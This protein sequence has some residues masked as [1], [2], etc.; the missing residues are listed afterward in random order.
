[1]SEIR[2]LQESEYYE[3]MRIVAEA[4][5]SM[6]VTTPDDI[7]KW[8]QRFKIGRRDPDWT[9]YG[10]FRDGKMVGVYRN[11][12]FIMNVRGNLLSAGGLGMVAVDLT[13][14]KE[15]VAKEIVDAFL[16]HYDKRGDA[17]TCLWPFRVDFY[18]RMGFGLGYRRYQ[19]RVHPAS[20]PPRREKDH[21]RYLTEV[22]IPAIVE[23]YNRCFEKQS[24]MI[25]HNEGRY[26]NRFQYAEKQRYIGCEVDGR[27][28]GYLIYSFKNTDRPNSFMD[29]DLVVTEFF[30][31]TPQ[32]LSELLAFLHSQLDQV[33][34][35]LLETSEDEFYFLMS[36]P[37]IASG[38]KMAPTYH[39]SHMAGVGIMYRVMDLGRLFDKLE[40]PCFG[41]DRLS[42]RINLTD[43]FLPQ[44]NGPRVV[45]FKGGRGK[46]ADTDQA[47]VEIALD[48]AE[49]SSLI[50]AAVGFEK[51]YTYGLAQ[52]SDQ[53]FINRLDR[54]FAYHQKPVCITG[55]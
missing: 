17:M 9:P 50:M 42:V 55:F 38:T 22:D 44:Y 16:S 24:G 3:S 27:L 23:C 45:Q 53:T 49:F 36:D 33:S 8:E 4:Y 6:G 32:A 7:R 34:R 48:V 10:V 30:Y 14:K 52:V 54:L 51:L 41:D 1:V 37:T 29:T 20:L 15:H 47:D 39:E 19:Y 18:H 11:F 5:P 21:I 12:D 28:D 2:V 43:P 25:R 26:L 46:V 13:H 31:H 35:L 40:K